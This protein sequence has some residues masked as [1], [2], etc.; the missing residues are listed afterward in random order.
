[1]P[2]H[3]D[4]SKRRENHTHMAFDKARSYDWPCILLVIY[5]PSMAAHNI[6][7]AHYYIGDLQ[8]PKNVTRSFCDSY[9]G[10]KLLFLPD[11]SVEEVWK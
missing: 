4:L 2:Q 7:P 5:Y 9:K 8:S 11:R 1:M 10:L 6:P 3:I